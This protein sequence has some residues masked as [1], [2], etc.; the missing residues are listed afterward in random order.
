MDFP[1]KKL[2]LESGFYRS[3]VE[4]ILSYSHLKVKKLFIEIIYRVELPYYY[5]IE[6]KCRSTFL[7]FDPNSVYNGRGLL[8]L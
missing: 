6:L 1:P 7:C 5:K 3:T 2:I 8:I 4:Y